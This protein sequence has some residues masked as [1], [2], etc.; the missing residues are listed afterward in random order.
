VLLLDDALRGLAQAVEVGPEG[1]H[2][3]AD[4]S[5][6]AARRIH[7]GCAWGAFAASGGLFKSTG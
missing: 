4:C 5:M 2:G 3:V 6:G 7:W 1:G